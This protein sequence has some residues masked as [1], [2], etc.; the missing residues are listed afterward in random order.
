MVGYH[1]KTVP[2]HQTSHNMYVL[3]LSPAS[4]ELEEVV[5]RR[6]K[7]S[8]RNN[9]AVDFV[10]RIKTMADSIDPRRNPYYNY[11]RYER[12][13]LALN[14]FEHTDSDALIK[15]FPFLLEHVDTSEVSG[16]P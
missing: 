15:R 9:P 7:Y 12:I 13:T 6:K 16:R 4:T 10:N 14:N 1:S 3:R 5:V 2:L 11:R 8:K